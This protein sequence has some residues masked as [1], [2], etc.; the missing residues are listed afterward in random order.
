MVYMNSSS[1]A[2]NLKLCELE[3][4]KKKKNVWRPNRLCQSG[5]NHLEWEIIIPE[6]YGLICTM[7]HEHIPHVVYLSAICS[8]FKSLICHQ[9][10][11]RLT[12]VE[13]VRATMLCAEIA[14]VRE[15]HWPFLFWII[16]SCTRTLSCFSFFMTP[17][18]KQSCIIHVAPRLWHCQYCICRPASFVAEIRVLLCPSKD[19]VHSDGSE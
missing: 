18:L 11:P 1:A 3:K 16:Q 17:S 14:S 12:C 6:K 8:W 9:S 4:C 2:F 7:A 19:C 13:S 10:F 15:L 5:C